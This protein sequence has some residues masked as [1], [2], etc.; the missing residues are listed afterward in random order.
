[1]IVDTPMILNAHAKIN[2][3]LDITGRL[4]NGYHTLT[5]V[6]Q[7]V[8]L[9]DRVTV[10]VS[11]AAIDE[12]HLSCSDPALPTDRGNLAFRAAELFLSETNGFARSPLSVR[13]H[14]EKHIPYPAGLAGGSTDAAAVLRGLNHL[15]GEPL[16]P[17]ALEALGARLGADVPFC[18]RGGTC[19]TE[20]I[21]DILTPCPALLACDILIACAG[22]GVSTP[23]AYRALD[24]AFGGFA[25][26]LYRPHLDELDRLLVSLGDGSLHG[27]GEHSFNLFES[28][29]LPRHSTAGR[30]LDKLRASGALCARM[31]GS[32]PSVFGLFPLGTA[33]PICAALRESGIPSW[34][35]HPTAQN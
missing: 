5:G 10:E 3:F 16:S 1:M 26:N 34:A 2:L 24:T 20:G 11:C 22:E 29:I 15:T 30:L 19:I 14:I 32:G 25:E 21:G 35:C 23:E 4:P 28:V 9:A 12:V 8:S 13:I 6:M 17:D 31:S 33:E 18:I 27:V 7:S